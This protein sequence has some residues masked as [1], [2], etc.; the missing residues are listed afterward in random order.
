LYS[1]FALKKRF[2]KKSIKL[3][4]YTINN[5]IKTFC[6]TAESFPEGISAAHEKLYSILP[7]TAGR[8]FFGISYGSSSPE[9]IYKAAVEESYP[10]KAEKYNCEVYI[11][12]KGNYCCE[13][14]VDW[15]KDI[16]LIGKTFELML[17]FPGVDPSGYCLELFLNKT[18]I[19]CL[20]K[21]K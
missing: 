3:N 21:L 16:P 20:V 4:I 10:G 7:D 5:D 12:K 19:L 1:N 8:N 14:L 17:R 9:I 11:I 6:I 13:K 18:D 15:R 2:L